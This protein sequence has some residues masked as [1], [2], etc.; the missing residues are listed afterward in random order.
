MNSD[1]TGFTT[2]DFPGENRSYPGNLAIAPDGKHLA[3]LAGYDLAEG[4]S[5]YVV[6]LPSGTYRTIDVLQP[7]E[8]FSIDDYY[9]GTASFDMTQARIAIRH[10]ASLAWSPDSSQLAFLGWMDGSS[11]DLYLYDLVS[12]DITQLTDGPSHAFQVY[13]SPD[14]RY[15]LHAGVDT[16]GTGAGYSMAGL[17]VVDV[18]R[19]AIYDVDMGMLQ[20]DFLFHGWLDDE[21]FLAASFNAVCGVFNLRAVNLQT[22]QVEAIWPGSYGVFDIDPS[23]WTM[24]LDAP[25]YALGDPLCNEP[26]LAGL[27]L[28]DETGN[29][30]QITL[31]GE[32]NGREPVSRILWSATL[33]AFVFEHG[34]RIG[35]LSQDGVVLED[36]PAFPC[37]LPN[38]TDW[39]FNTNEP[40][41]FWAGPA[42]TLPEIEIINCDASNWTWNPDGSIVIFVRD[43]NLVIARG[44]EFEPLLAAQDVSPVPYGLLW[45]G[46]E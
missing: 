13:W 14:G 6:D 17:W 36:L 29:A 8:D 35:M 2:L 41:G 27:L 25:E 9:P 34:E 44:P 46:E 24:L 19:D 42:G 43:E 15:L 18:P 33:D 22:G 30:N 11:V 1:G 23:T 45:A 26:S 31:A 38:N 5:L 40:P 4:I 32:S 16:F 39:A 3:F 7:F 20:G 21:T 10:D 37:L 28:V 12:D